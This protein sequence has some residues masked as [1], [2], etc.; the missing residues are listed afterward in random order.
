[1]LKIV[2]RIH[3]RMQLCRSRLYLA[4]HSWLCLSAR[5]WGWLNN[6]SAGRVSELLSSP[7]STCSWSFGYLQFPV[8]GWSIFSCISV[9]W[10]SLWLSTR[11]W[12]GKMRNYL[13]LLLQLQH[14]EGTA[15]TFVK[16]SCEKQ[17]FFHNFMR[18]I[19][20]TLNFFIKNRPHKAEREFGNR[21]LRTSNLPV[22]RKFVTGLCQA[23]TALPC[24][25]CV[26]TCPW[27]IDVVKVRENL[28]KAPC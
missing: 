6:H 1:M 5:P 22:V 21:A 2:T 23:H 18:V 9:L 14:Y 20:L 16:M 15:I 3:H 10:K 24:C 19:T 17:Q 27:Y 28:W 11:I 25:Q 26:A 8:W 12:H 13:L 4:V 7:H